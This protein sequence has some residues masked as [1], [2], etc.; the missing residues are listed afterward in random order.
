MKHFSRLCKINILGE[1]M[2]FITVTK[3]K[4]FNSKSL[5]LNYKNF[6]GGD[7]RKE[8]NGLITG[9]VMGID[10]LVL[11]Q[12]YDNEELEKDFKEMV[13]FYLS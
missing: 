5:N 9:K 4:V 11:F 2:N 13:D 3:E 1:R 7:L 10:D 8:S 12:G 6:T